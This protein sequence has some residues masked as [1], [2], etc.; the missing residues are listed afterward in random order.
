M[1]ETV[2]KWPKNLFIIDLGINL[3]QEFL[4]KIKK[5]TNTFVE[6]QIEHLDETYKYATQICSKEWF[7]NQKIKQNEAALKYI[8]H[9]RS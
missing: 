8:Q 5:L 7:T 9:F 4:D 6:K 3:E 2:K 1:I